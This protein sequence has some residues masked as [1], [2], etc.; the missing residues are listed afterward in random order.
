MKLFSLTLLCGAFSATSAFSCLP[1]HK[2]SLSLRLPQYA[3]VSTHA[4]P[5]THLTTTTMKSSLD[6]ELG[7]IDY[8]PVFDGKTTVALIGG[9]TVLVLLAILAAKFLVSRKQ[10]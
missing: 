4:K 2:N 3:P 8:D 1:T 6:D 7:R 10:F 5:Y 9:Q